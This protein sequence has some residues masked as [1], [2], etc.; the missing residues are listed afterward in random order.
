[1]PKSDMCSSHFCGPL[2]PVQLRRTSGAPG[3]RRSPKVRWPLSLEERSER[4][5]YFEGKATCAVTVFC[6]T[7]ALVPLALPLDAIIIGEIETIC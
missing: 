6:V 4:N 2:G 7:V 5:D 3:G 1:M